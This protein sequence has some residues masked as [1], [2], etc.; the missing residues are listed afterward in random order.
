MCV[1]SCGKQSHSMLDDGKSKKRE[2][3][4]SDWPKSGSLRT[5][6]ERVRRCDEASPI[7]CCITFVHLVVPISYH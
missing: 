6:G 4:F 2:E 7:I 1:E 5:N 3:K